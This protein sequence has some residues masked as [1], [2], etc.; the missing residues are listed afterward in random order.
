MAN[1]SEPII[2]LGGLINKGVLEGCGIPR[3]VAD[4]K[5]VVMGTIKLTIK[6]ST[7]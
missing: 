1:A 7:M 3:P 5:V 2:S 6:T 4:V